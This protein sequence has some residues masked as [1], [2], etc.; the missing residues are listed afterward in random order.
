[1]KPLEIVNRRENRKELYLYVNDLN[2]IN[3]EYSFRQTLFLNGFS[4]VQ[5]ETL[6][7]LEILKVYNLFNPLTEEFNTFLIFS[8]EI[9]FKPSQ[10]IKYN[11]IGFKIFNFSLENNYLVEIL[12]SILDISRKEMPILLKTIWDDNL[13]SSYYTHFYIDNLPKLAIDGADK[14]GIAL[15]GY[16]TMYFINEIPA[17]ESVIRQG[18]GLRRDLLLIT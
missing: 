18:Q 14:N 15:V 13:R 9:N 10:E 11:Y 8:K 7:N 16:Y 2:F 4:I 17:S 3:E 5:F 1:M 6:E 12:T